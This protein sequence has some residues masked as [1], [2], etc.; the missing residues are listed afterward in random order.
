MGAYSAVHGRDQPTPR[1][2]QSNGRFVAGR[3]DQGLNSRP[4]A[5][6]FRLFGDL[7]SIADFPAEVPNSAFE[8]MDREPTFVSEWNW[9]D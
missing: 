5:S 8:P 9:P 4:N 1:A 3:A 7:K 2:G 6:D